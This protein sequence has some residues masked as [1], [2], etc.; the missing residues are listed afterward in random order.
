MPVIH[1]LSGAAALFFGALLSAHSASAAVN[2]LSNPYFTTPN[3]NGTSTFTGLYEGPSGAAD[4]TVFNNTNGTTNTDLEPSTL[5]RGG[6]MIHVTTT[7]MNNGLE[8]VFTAKGKGEKYACAWLYIVSGTVGI[9]AGNGGS[10]GIDIESSTTGQWLAL[11]A[12]SGRGPATLFIAYAT[13]IGDAEYYVTTTSV[14]G[15]KKTCRA[16]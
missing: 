9:G 6:T 13:S 2:L 16:K 8:Q 4:W 11:D 14:N 5:V 1:G 12:H 7:G 3:G 15:S 10:T